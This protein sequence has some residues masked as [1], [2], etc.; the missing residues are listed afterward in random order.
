MVF[1]VAESPRDVSRSSS[2]AARRTPSDFVSGVSVV[3]PGS[4]ARSLPQRYRH[5]LRC[6]YHYG[7]P[8][9]SHLPDRGFPVR[10]EEG[11]FRPAVCTLGRQGTLRSQVL[12]CSSRTVF[13]LC[14]QPFSIS[15]Q[16][17]PVRVASQGIRGNGPRCFARPFENRLPRVSPATP[18]LT[19]RK[20]WS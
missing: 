6:Y 2:Q 13:S 11:S 16:N 15:S 1:R 3:Q 5:P 7:C 19:R 12:S 20:T 18:R 10:S 14:N 9:H 8:E 17:L 4:P